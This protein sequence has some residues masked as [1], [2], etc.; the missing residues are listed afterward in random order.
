M[1]LVRGLSYFTTM[2]NQCFLN[3]ILSFQS[4]LREILATS[5]EQ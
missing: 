1:D 3:D 5:G 4:I 2:K